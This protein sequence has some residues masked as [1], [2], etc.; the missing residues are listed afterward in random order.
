MNHILLTCLKNL[1]VNKEN[2]FLILLRNY[3]FYLDEIENNEIQDIVGNIVL[4]NNI[5]NEML[6]LNL[7]GNLNISLKIINNISKIN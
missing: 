3:Y 4:W 1:G 7:F 5:D 6:I 2:L